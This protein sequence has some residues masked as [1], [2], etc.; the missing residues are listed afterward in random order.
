VKSDNIRPS[1][2]TTS[3]CRGRLSR[4]N[5]SGFR[6]IGRVGKSSCLAHYDANARATVAARGQFFDTT[7]VENSGGIA[8]VFGKYFGKFS[9]RAHCDTENFFEHRL[10]DHLFLLRSWAAEVPAET[11]PAERRSVPAPVLI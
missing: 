10:F 2:T 11:S 8:S 4:S 3:R 9:A 6:K 5:E 7:I 1:T